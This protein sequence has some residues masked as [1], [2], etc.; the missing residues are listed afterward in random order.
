L[1]TDIELE[2]CFTLHFK[3]QAF[4]NALSLLTLPTTLIFEMLLPLTTEET[5]TS[6]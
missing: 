1:E 4:L 6:L 3:G 5:Q 2:V